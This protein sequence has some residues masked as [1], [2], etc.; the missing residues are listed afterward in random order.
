MPS[1]PPLLPDWIPG[2]SVEPSRTHEYAS[3]RRIHWSP[4][5]V[6]ASVS[7]VLVICVVAWIVAHPNKAPHPLETASLALVVPPLEPPEPPQP[8]TTP[9]VAAI[10]AFHRAPSPEGI[11]ESL[12]VLEEELPPPPSPRPKRMTLVESPPLPL[13]EEQS[14]QPPV[15]EAASPPPAGETYGTQVL[16][17]HN[18]EA[19]ADRARRDRK[20]LFVMHIS[21]NF[22]DSCFT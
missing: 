5:V 11:V 21:G 6:S 22:E 12:P 18:R 19:A 10:P 3:L 7:F 16:F 13:P 15:A 2:R 20:L 17:L 9:V 8:Q 1:T 14:P 4:I